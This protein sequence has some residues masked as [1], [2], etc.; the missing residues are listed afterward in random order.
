MYHSLIQLL[1]TARLLDRAQGATIS[2]LVEHLGIDRRSVYRTLNALDELNYPWYKDEDHD[3]RYRLMNGQRASKWWMPLPS[4]SFG[5]EDRIILDWLFDSAARSSLL[6]VKVR[7]LRGKLAFLGAA[8][9]IA[10]EPKESGA[11][12][13]GR[14]R[15]LF[16]SPV[17]AKSLPE[18]SSATLDTLLS[19]TAKRLVCEVSYEARETGVVKTYDIH[20]LAVFESEG[21]LYVFVLVPWYGS[22]RILALERIRELIAKSESFVPPKDFDAEARLADPFGM[23]QG[24]PVKIRLRFSEGQAPYVRDR[25]WPETYCFQ[26][27]EDGRLLMSFETGGIFGLKR[28]VLSWGVDAEVLEPVWLREEMKSELAAMIEVYS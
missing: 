10:L 4:V 25:V 20:P 21:G 12:S 3:G 27:E 28:W 2:E 26:E 17:L 11:G 19:A 13:S 7:E 9:G 23:V 22:I 14:V 6:A 15:L 16:E 18:G 8:T 1:A 24:D 5:L